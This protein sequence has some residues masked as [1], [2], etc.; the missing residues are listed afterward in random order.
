MARQGSRPRLPAD[1]QRA[2]TV[3][4]GASGSIMGLVGATV[5]VHL[6]GWAR[7][8]ARIASRRLLFLV[9]VIAFQVVFDL[10][11]P[12]VSFLAHFGGVLIGFV[13]ASLMR[14]RVSGRAASPG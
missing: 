13:A 5:A 1:G 3:V 6:R 2:D 14:H 12:E 10:A 7:E 11:T 4:V 9:F 8:R